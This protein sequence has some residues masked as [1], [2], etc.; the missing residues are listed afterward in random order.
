MKG[1]INVD[2][3][4]AVILFVSV[5]A[6]LYMLLP[7]ATISFKKTPDPLWT[8]SHYFADVLMTSPGIPS[9]W[10][11]IGEVQRLGLAYG[12]NITSYSNILDAKKIGAIGGQTCSL[13]KSKTDTLLDFSIAVDIVNASAGG[14]SL[15]GDGWSYRK[16]VTIDNSANN[17]S[18]T[19]YQVL[20]TNP[21]YNETG[22][23][24]S[25]HFDEGYGNYTSDGSGNG[26][27]GTYYNE[28]RNDGTLVNSPTW[29]GGKYGRAV[30][31]PGQGTYVDAGNSNSL[32]LSDSFTIMTWVK[33]TDSTPG[34]YWNVI[35]SK[36]QA[37]YPNKGWRLVDRIGYGQ[38]M[39]ANGTSYVSIVANWIA[40]DNWHHLTAT[41]KSK[42]N[43]SLFIDGVEVGNTTLVGDFV[44]SDNQ[45]VIGGRLGGH[46]YTGVVDSVR[47]FNRGLTLDEIRAEMNSSRAA[48]LPVGA[49]EFNEGSGTTAR[50]THIWTNGTFDSSLGFDGSNNFVNINHSTS[51]N[52]NSEVTIATWVRPRGSGTFRYITAKSTYGLNV[53]PY[54]LIGTDNK[55]EW[56]V[57]NGTSYGQVFSNSMLSDNQWYHVAAT[58]DSGGNQK[59]YI[60]GVLDNSTT[61]PSFSL[62]TNSNNLYIGGASHGQLFNGSIDEVRIYNRSLSPS[63]IQDLYQA[64]AKLNY[65]DIRFTSNDGST[66][67]NHWKE[68]DG[69]FW[70]KV[71]A[72]PSL[73]TTTIYAYYGNPSANSTSNGNTTFLA[74]DDFNNENIDSSIWNVLSGNGAISEANGKINFNYNGVEDNNWWTAGRP[75]KALK[76]SRLPSGD[77]HAQVKLLNYNPS[78]VTHAGLTV[79]QDD[80]HAYF[81]GR[82][83]TDGYLNKYVLE[84]VGGGNIA[85]YD[86]TA[87][88]MYLAVRKNG[89]TY[90]FY[91]STDGSLWTQAGSTYSDVTFNNIVLMGKDWGTGSA[92]DLNFSM[93]N[94][95]TRKYS[96]I[97]PT[98]YIGT[99][100]SG[101]GV[102]N[103]CNYKK[104]LNFT[105]AWNSENLVNFPVLVKLNSSRINYSST[106]ATDIRFY[107]S[108][109][110]TLLP[111]ETERWNFSG[112]SYLWVKVPQIN[113]NTNADYIYAYYGC[114]DVNANDKYNVWDSNFKMVQHL[115]ETSGTHYD[116]TTYGANGTPYG[117][118]VQGNLSGKINGGNVQ[119]GEDDYVQISSGPVMLTGNFTLEAWAQ[120]R[121]INTGG[122]NPQT[123]IGSTIDCGG[124]SITEDWS[125]LAFYIPI[126]SVSAIYPTT[127]ANIKDKWTHFVYVKENNTIK[128]YVNG[129]LNG[130]QTHNNISIMNLTSSTWRIGYHGGCS[131]TVKPFNGTLDEIRISNISRTAGWVNATYLTEADGF[132]AYEG[133]QMGGWAQDNCGFRKKIN[134]T[135]SWNAENLTN[136]PAL[137]KLNSNRIDYS[138]TS[139]SDIRFYDADGTTLLPKETELWNSSGDSYVWV[140]VPRIDANSNTDY[141][142]AY[143]GC[144]N[145]NNDDRINVWGSGFKGV[146]HLKESSGTIYDSTSSLENGTVNGAIN[147]L[148][149]SKIGYVVRNPSSGRFNITDRS[150]GESGNFTVEAWFRYTNDD[151]GGI[152]TRHQGGSTGSWVFG[153]RSNKTTFGKTEQYIDSVNSVSDG[154]WHYLAGVLIPNSFEYIYID[155]VQNQSGAVGTITDTDYDIIIFDESSSNWDLAGDLDEVRI[156]SVARS[157][158]WVNASYLSESDNF[159][160]Y[161]SEEGVGVTNR[162]GNNCN[163]RKKLGFN[164]YWDQE[165]LTDFPVSIRLNSSRID[166]SKTGA[167]DIRFYDYNGA[168]LLPKETELWNSSGDSYLWVKVPKIDAGTNADYIYAYYGCSDAN[169]DNKV[170]VW[171]SNF[172]LVQH[173]S[174]TS[175]IHYDSSLYG[176][177]GTIS[178]TVIRGNASGKIDGA[179]VFDGSTGYIDNGNSSVLNIPDAIT[180]TGWLKM[181]TYRLNTY[182]GIV[183][184]VNTVEAAG[185]C[186]TNYALATSWWDPRPDFFITTT[187][188]STCQHF[189]GTTYMLNDTWYYVAGTYNASTGQAKIYL[190]GRQENSITYAGNITI[191]PY[192]VTIGKGNNFWNGTVDEI[193]ILNVSRSAAWINASYLSE[194]D[195]FISYGTEETSTSTQ[196]NCNYR[197][198]INITNS[199]NSESLTDFPLLIKLTL[200][201][202]DYSKTNATDIRFYDD[203]AITLLPKETELW[204]ASGESYVWVKVPRINANSDADYIYVYYGCSNSNIDNKTDVWDSNFKMVH[205][206]KE[207]SGT[208]FDST[209]YG[210]NGTAYEGTIQG[211]ASGKI[212]GADVFDGI[213]DYVSIPDSPT[214]EPLNLTVSVWAKNTL[215]PATTTYDQLILS[216]DTTSYTSTGYALTWGWGDDFYWRAGNGTIVQNLVST[217]V[218][219]G[220]TWYHIVGTF[221]NGEQ[222][223]YINGILIGTN[224]LAFEIPYNTAPLSIGK[225]G[226]YRLQGTIDEVR[227]SNVSRTDKWINASYLSETD[228]FTSFGSEQDLRNTNLVGND[229][230]YRAKFT[231][232]N[233]WNSQNLTN[234]PVL[235]KLNPS[236]IDYS[237]TSATDIRF[238]DA[239]TVTLLPKETEKWSSSG[240]SFVWVRVPQIDA[241][242]NADYIWAYYGC[243][244]ANNDDKTV[245]WNS[246][247][248]GV[249][250]LSETSGT[251]YD[252]TQY[253]NNGTPY[254]G[255]IQGNA[256]G[257]ID[258]ADVFD[259]IDD[260]INGGNSSTLNFYNASNFTMSFWMYPLQHQFTQTAVG[261]LC[262]YSTCGM[263]IYRGDPSFSTAN[264]AFG[265]SANDVIAFKKRSNPGESIMTYTFP[266][267]DMTNSW[268]HI[269]GV[270]NENNLSVYRNGA[271]VGSQ[272]IGVINGSMSNQA[273]YIGGIYKYF[274]GTVD[275]ARISNITRSAAWINAS[276]L[277]ENDA[278][279]NYGLEESGV[280]GTY[281]CSSTIPKKARLIER[282]GYLKNGT[283]YTPIK[284]KIWTW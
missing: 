40:D 232:N 8:A 170:N 198:T 17:N 80:T 226:P 59:V 177:N 125:T 72:I 126:D 159:A 180:I 216:K 261:Q 50:D 240:S 75:E 171:D 71:P 23:V 282:I 78:D 266:T 247:F 14:G 163:Y 105:N 24:S 165:N 183:H 245:V 15:L 137:I 235:V 238:Y 259:G 135:N 112:D 41:L 109:G 96:S 204:N 207:T 106:G 120:Y 16:A 39:M 227:I 13:L 284:V 51:L 2:F 35:V 37:D 212:D 97:E 219:R 4:M 3:V 278:F 91:W 164:N 145:V 11:T 175:G 70:V 43:V 133:E 146:W 121:G 103:N 10:G 56:A 268:N 60:N 213:D 279:I 148:Q 241:N 202:I 236:R 228:S 274:N 77:F 205:H 196:N 193:R 179:D 174:E 111:K 32:N 66:L 143:Y 132:I 62:N 275:E 136:F 128:A 65:D 182:A 262:A 98:V 152:I 115:G 45:L 209:S 178:G 210:N 102:G 222:K 147:Y 237:K 114:S 189:Q 104:R 234:F 168:T 86:S 186:G 27:D 151:T 199:W 265:M 61:R 254:Q 38:V 140:K 283:E 25:W 160:S 217:T 276:Y 36:D 28:N 21:I 195:N 116:S 272:I 83:R 233:S 18:L 153:L 267:T 244:D 255:V 221:R 138:K 220:D 20:V 58:F 271:F 215:T 281:S 79:Y 110:T 249:W 277:S 73:N 33:T 155:G 269:V 173:L 118:V 191:S 131:G 87:L 47:Y 176:N 22:L 129:A 248:K 256:S 55:I 158:A 161:G 9:N 229:C 258:G 184:K 89:T 130:S 185:G 230:N 53:P 122:G 197:K 94:F 127:I 251:Q 95:L 264:Y 100:Q 194:N 74:F 169:L 246:D 52:L 263:A 260:Y 218:A 64:K 270:F 92:N 108:D 124:P 84:K 172:K 139:A 93:D 69:K 123:V 231:F 273:F 67:L 82:Y 46:N 1:D 113:A 68:A 203:N 190:N 99:S 101:G 242:S 107:D 49:W 19:D 223:L 88:P 150:F 206:F 29:V 142:Y 54:L 48:V 76:L 44:P 211:N 187:G 5:Y 280:S 192:Y 239:D 7:A 252:S 200:N 85:S 157:A 134:F 30:Y 42:K 26:N 208:H 166:Y 224:N 188:G 257:K 141:I 34:E 253:M 31:F 149:Y 167:T 57:P 63:E 144:A 201:K 214:L 225:V 156:S 12:D 6:M 181:N 119:D 243:T 162:V 90:S 117:G 250:H 154:N 81:W